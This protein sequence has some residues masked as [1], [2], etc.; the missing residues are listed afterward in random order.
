MAS[1]L[2]YQG[3]RVLHQGKEQMW[4]SRFV[5]KNDDCDLGHAGSVVPMRKSN[6]GEQGQAQTTGKDGLEVDQKEE[7]VSLIS[8]LSGTLPE[9][10][11]TGPTRQQCAFKERV[12]HPK[13]NVRMTQALSLQVSKTGHGGPLTTALPSSSATLSCSA[14]AAILLPSLLSSPKYAEQ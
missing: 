11:A 10:A 7:S 6:L 9:P 8:T 1:G 4:Y 14:T 2:R 13:R 3:W 12:E 5:G